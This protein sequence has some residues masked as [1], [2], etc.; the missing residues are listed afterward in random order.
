MIIDGKAIANEIHN[1]IKQTV[2][3]LAGRKP[4]IAVILVGED[5]AS[6]VYVNRKVQGCEEVGILS[7][8]KELPAD[9][10]EKHL[11]EEIDELN[12]DPNIDGI[13]VQL[14]L[15]NHI[16]SVKVMRHIDPDKDVDGFHPVNM[17]KMLIGETDGFIPCTPL[18]IKTLLEKSHIDTYGKH[19][20]V[21]GRSNIVGKPMAALLLQREAGFNCSLSVVN[22]YT[23]DVKRF[24][25]E[26]DILIVAI[27]QPRYIKADM[28]KEGAVIID[29]GINKEDGKL[30]GDVDFE[31]VKNKC[32]M[33]TPVPGGVGPM[34]IAMLLKNTLSSYRRRLDL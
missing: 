31:E 30:V 4:C 2:N 5:P 14:P 1:E 19:I 17:G 28:I 21:V 34:T 11:L 18:G 6:H 24:C 25:K 23:P 32:S 33:I 12:D 7:I 16:N 22:R 10:S 9:I 20:V 13:L 26:A 8:K 27:G 29:V 3:L 15:P